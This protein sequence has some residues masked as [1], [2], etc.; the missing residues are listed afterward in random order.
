MTGVLPP[1]WLLIKNVVGAEMPFAGSLTR[2][3]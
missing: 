3:K 2:S 1:L